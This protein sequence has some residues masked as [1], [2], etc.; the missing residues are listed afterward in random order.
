MR[1]ATILNVDFVCL[2]V[3]LWL[4]LS[5]YIYTRRT[6]PSWSHRFIRTPP[7]LPLPHPSHGHRYQFESPRKCFDRI[8][9]ACNRRSDPNHWILEMKHMYKLKS[10]TPIHGY[11]TIHVHA[12][13]SR[14]TT[15]FIWDRGFFVDH[16]AGKASLRHGESDVAWVP[17]T[18]DG[19]I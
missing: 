6:A 4:C 2:F 19:D 1:F 7:L 13:K 9:Y 11:I 18:G 10:Q 3:C 17:N 5:L 14:L 15:L 16:I 12:C 8:F